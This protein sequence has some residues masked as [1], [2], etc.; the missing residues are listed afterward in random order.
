MAVCPRPSALESP[1][2]FQLAKPVMYDNGDFDDDCDDSDGGGKNILPTL[3][4]AKVVVGRRRKRYES[5]A[6][7]I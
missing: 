6:D 4:S 7:L 5:I 1:K 2:H 3:T